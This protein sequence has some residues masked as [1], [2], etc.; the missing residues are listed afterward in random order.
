MIT[1]PLSTMGKSLKLCDYSL[2]DD[3]LICSVIHCQNHS[4]ADFQN[5][6]M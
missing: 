5:Y 6:S 1:Q 3:K 2:A 4:R